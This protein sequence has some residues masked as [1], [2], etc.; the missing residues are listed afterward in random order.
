MP[1]CCSFQVSADA[2]LDWGGGREEGQAWA[3]VGYIL[4]SEVRGMADECWAG[5]QKREQVQGG[6][7][8]SVGSGGPT[9]CEAAEA[10][11]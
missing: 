1:I 11:G 2:G 3:K 6:C 9:V 7:P 5:V 8:D 4:E 10:P